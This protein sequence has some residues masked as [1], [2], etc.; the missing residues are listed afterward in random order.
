MRVNLGE[1]EWKN[2]GNKGGRTG[3]RRKELSKKFGQNNKNHHVS[4]NVPSSQAL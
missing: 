4:A 1:E 3:E 2:R